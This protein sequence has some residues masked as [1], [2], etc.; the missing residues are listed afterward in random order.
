MVQITYVHNMLLLLFF[1]F[2]ILIYISHIYLY[3]AALQIKSQEF[4]QKYQKSGM[5][6]HSKKKRRTKRFVVPQSK[7]TRDVEEITSKMFSKMFSFLYE[8]RVVSFR[9]DRSTLHKSKRFA[10]QRHSSCSTPV[11]VLGV[12]KLFYNIYKAP[13]T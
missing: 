11:T 1:Y 8:C 10:R 12:R 3:F 7:V 5:R 6:N 4:I 13:T 2:F 9:Q